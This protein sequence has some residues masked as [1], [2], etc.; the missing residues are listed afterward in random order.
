MNLHRFLEVL[1]SGLPIIGE[2]EV[3]CFMFFFTYINC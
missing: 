3:H 1:N 2:S